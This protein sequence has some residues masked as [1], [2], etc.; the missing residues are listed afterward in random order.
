MTRAIRSRVLFTILVV[1]LFCALVAL[2]GFTINNLDERLSTAND[3]VAAKDAQIAALLDDLHASQEN[4][5]ALFDQIRELGET[6]Q[7]ENPRLI[8]GPAGETG[9]RGPRG[10]P[11]MDGEDGADG[12][13]GADSTIPGPQGIP[14][15]PGADS[16]V[17]GPAGQDGAKG[18]KGDPGT[19]GVGIQTVTCQENGDWIFTRTDQTTITVPGPCRVDPITEGATP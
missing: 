7:G 16:T 19:P 9:E 13:D 12:A 6:P 17:P 11:G 10:F 1:G 2:G 15:I 14:G 4:A 5:Q 3:R 18:D 8:A